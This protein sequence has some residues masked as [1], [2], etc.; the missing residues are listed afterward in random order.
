MDKIDLTLCK[1][2][3]CPT[4]I[5]YREMCL[6]IRLTLEEPARLTALV[7]QIY[8]PVG[9]TTDKN[10]TAVE[11]NLRTVVRRAWEVNPTYLVEIAGRPLAHKPETGEFLAMMWGYLADGEA[12]DVM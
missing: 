4:Y 9:Q 8:T 6:A 10:W 11:R 3:I 2:G 1:L 5:G 12:A 7:R